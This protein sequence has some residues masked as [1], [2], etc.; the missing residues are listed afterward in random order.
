M[1]PKDPLPKNGHPAFQ[2]NLLH[3]VNVYLHS[4]S[5]VSHVCMYENGESLL[6]CDQLQKVHWV[7]NGTTAAAAF[8]DVMGMKHA[9]IKLGKLGTENAV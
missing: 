3:L 6:F 8:P 4:S 9:T 2:F 1:F 7:I 5:D